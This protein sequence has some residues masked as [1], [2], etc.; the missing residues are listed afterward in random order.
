[1]SGFGT[2]EIW[3][4]D[5]WY[6]YPLPIRK[7]LINELL[8]NAWIQVCSQHNYLERY[9]TKVGYG[10]YATGE[11]IHF[12]FAQDFSSGDYYFVYAAGEK[13]V[14]GLIHP[15]PDIED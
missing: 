4:Y 8:T 12:I 5:S 9:L 3:S 7:H 11:Y 13:N 10:M 14:V 1:M 15:N 6:N 2:L